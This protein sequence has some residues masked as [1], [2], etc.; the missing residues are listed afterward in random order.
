MK[1]KLFGKEGFTLIELMTVVII[2][3][4]LAAVAVPLYRG[5]VKKAIAS[6]GAAL[7]GAVRS[8]QRVYYAENEAYTD[9]KDE[10]S[11]DT[12]DNKY[13]DWDDVTLS[14]VTATTFTATATGRTGSDAAGITVS[15]D[16]TGDLTYTG[17]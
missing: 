4:V 7:V 17:L 15:I 6:E 9:D 2:V 3:G 13:F 12:F 11:L 5:Q 16:Q 1:K 14:D 8:A 10:L